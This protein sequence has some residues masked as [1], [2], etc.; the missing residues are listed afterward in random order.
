MKE[1]LYLY[2]DIA[3][4]LQREHVSMSC[5]LNILHKLGILPAYPLSSLLAQQGKLQ[6]FYG[7]P[8]IFWIKTA[9]SHFS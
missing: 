8:Y 6:P 1:N 3:G 5:N 7:P 4:V 2:S 9:A